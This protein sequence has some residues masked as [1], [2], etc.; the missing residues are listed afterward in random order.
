VQPL[1][2]RC[3]ASTVNLAEVLTVLV[4][5]GATEIEALRMVVSLG[6][7]AAPLEFLHAQRAA[8][9]HP[10]TFAHGLSTG[11]RCCLAL[12]RTLGVPAYTT[13]RSWS[14]LTGVGVEIRVIR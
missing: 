10:K 14:K 3:G 9:L 5:R 13:D 12:A 7:E 8:F 6:I 11:D 1:L 4:R 2:D